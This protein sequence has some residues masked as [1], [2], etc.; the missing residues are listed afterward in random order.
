MVITPTAYPL[1][2]E[3]HNEIILPVSIDVEKR[4]VVS[5]LTIFLTVQFFRLAGNDGLN[6]FIADI[7]GWDARSDAGDWNQ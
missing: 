3:Q 1:N 2:R 6:K 4:L 7:A 5:E